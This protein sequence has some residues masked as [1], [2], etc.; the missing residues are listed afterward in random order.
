MVV[1]AIAEQHI[2]KAEARLLYDDLTPKPT[3]EEVEM[4]RIA[5][6]AAPFTRPSTAGAPDRRE[7]RALRRLKG[8][9]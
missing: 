5:R 2:P 7:R 1:K 6:L 3:A 9:G 4:R 8:R